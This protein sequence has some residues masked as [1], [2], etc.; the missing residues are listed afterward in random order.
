MAERVRLLVQLWAHLGQQE[1]LRE[2]ESSLVATARRHGAEY[3]GR[4]RAA[5]LPGFSGDAPPPDEVH[6]LTF[7]SMDAMQAYVEDPAR[8]AATERLPDV[9]AVRSVW[10]LEDL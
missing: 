9:L 8:A 1:G 5:P 4:Y 10:V 2:V 6:V 3:E 7:P